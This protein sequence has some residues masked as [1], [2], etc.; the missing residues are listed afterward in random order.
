MTMNTPFS[1]IDYPSLTLQ[2]VFLKAFRTFLG[3]VSYLLA[4]STF[5]FLLW[6]KICEKLMVIIAFKWT[7]LEFTLSILGKILEALIA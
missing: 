3:A 4:V 7:L 5:F 2:A 6:K 1:L